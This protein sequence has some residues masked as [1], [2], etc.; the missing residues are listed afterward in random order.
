MIQTDN[1]LPYKTPAIHH[2]ATSSY[3]P[4]ITIL[5]HQEPDSI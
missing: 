3:I 4:P 1:K 5:H 2:R